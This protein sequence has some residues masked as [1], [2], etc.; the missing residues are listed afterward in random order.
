MIMIYQKSQKDYL[1]YMGLFRI[2]DN[3]LI[4]II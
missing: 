1:K 3:N 4:F 2:Y